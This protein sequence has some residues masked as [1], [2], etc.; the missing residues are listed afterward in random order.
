MLATGHLRKIKTNKGSGYK[1]NTET[2]RGADGKR[3]RQ[4]VTFYGTRKQ[5]EHKLREMLSDI[6]N[7]THMN[8]SSPVTVSQWMNKW[9]ATYIKDKKSPTTY[10]GYKGQ[11]DTH[12]LPYFENVYL[13]DLTTLDVQ[14][15]VNSLY[16]KSHETN[17]DRNPKTVKNIFMNLKAACNKAVQADIIPKNPCDGVELKKCDSKKVDPYTKEEVDELM[18]AMK[19]DEIEFPIHLDLILGLRRG[20]LLALKW[21]D[22]DYGKKQVHIQRNIVLDEN[23]KIVEKTPKSKSGNRYISLSESQCLMLKLEQTKQQERASKNINYKD[24]DLVVCKA[25]GTYYNPDVFSSKF[26]RLLEKIGLRHIRLHDIRH[27][28]CT[29]LLLSGVNMKTMQGRLGHSDYSVTANTYSHVTAE[30]DRAA[31]ELAD[32]FI[33]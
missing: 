5:A 4:S 21:S 13:K 23:R 31:S 14:E 29:L 20:E 3:H 24:N 33:L 17:K 8:K 2:P 28:N 16:N 19:G 27:T 10:V 6:E 22:I 15:W 12:I 1:I 30:A 18:K 32:S 7:G 9:L 11:V 25:D 26:N